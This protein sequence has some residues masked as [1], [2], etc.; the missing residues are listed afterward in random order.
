[1]QIVKHQEIVKL[2]CLIEA[3]KDKFK[4]IYERT[5]K[6]KYDE[7]AVRNGFLRARIVLVVKLLVFQRYSL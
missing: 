4:G 6:V 5:V 7:L 1:M 3:T 2:Q